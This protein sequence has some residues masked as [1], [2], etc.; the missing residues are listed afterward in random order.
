MRKTFGIIIGVIIALLLCF[1]VS[2]VTY[3]HSDDYTSDSFPEGVTINGLDCS[4]MTYEEAEKALSEYWNGQKM[5]VVGNLQ[6]TLA[7]YT[8]FGCTYDIAKNIA[9]V[10][11]DNLVKSALN[12]YLHIPYS[13]QMAMNVEKT[14]KKFRKE[15]KH[16]DFLMHGDPIVTQDA[17]V[18]MDDPT[19]PIIPEVYG[20]K[21]DTDAYFDGIVKGIE[22]GELRFQFDE[23]D[24]IDVPEVKSDDPQL[25]N[26][27]RCCKEYLTQKITYELGKESFT[28][29]A[30][31]I[32]EMLK[33]I[34]SGEA[35][36]AA[37]ARYVKKLAAD[38]N[39]VGSDVKF[40]SFT[41]KTFTVNGG[42]YGWA[43]D[44]EAETAQLV[45]D[46]NTHKDISREPIFA[47]RGNGEYTK[48]VGDTYIDVDISQQHAWYFE[49]GT[50][51]WDSD[52]VS[53]CVAAGH[54]TPTGVFQVLNKARNVTL[55]G[56][57]KKKKTYYESFVSYWMAFLGGSYG[58]HDATWRSQ[59]GGDIYKYAG[60]HGCVNIPPSRMPDLYNIVSVGTPV[61]VHY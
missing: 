17:Y 21:P 41:G 50:S 55:K 44:Q 24:Y 1:G 45:K 42:T 39:T 9:N 23:K 10:K 30:D 26:Y 58:L 46:I 48:L 52:I 35:D 33:S 54:S 53:G 25:L 40:T 36:P 57:S 16:S 6:E 27:Q 7:E 51:R 61:I 59:F 38:Y 49:N 3:T 11:R 34:E 32:Q 28:V 12:H 20:N 37:V 8:D 14:S 29:S 60:S 5:V 15:V 19:Y 43:I 47:V 31:D 22:L 2:A 13:V 4:G 18:D 56:G